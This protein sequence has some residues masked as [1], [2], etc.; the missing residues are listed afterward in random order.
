MSWLQ[1]SPATSIAHGKRADEP[2]ACASPEV[3]DAPLLGELLAEL[4]EESPI[5]VLD[6][7]PAAPANLDF[8]ARFSSGLRI[9]DLL[10]DLPQPDPEDPDD[11]P[12]VAVLARLARG[13]DPRY[14]LI[15]LWDTLDSLT[16][17]RSTVLAHHLAA[18]TTPGGRLHAMTASTAGTDSGVTAYEIVEPGRLRYRRRTA[19]GAT[20]AA[21]PPAEVERR[22]LPFRV[23]RSVL[24][25]HGIRE[26]IAVLD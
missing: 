15:L 3:H 7:G 2:T 16:A 1:R 10:R 11:A 25:R 19:G 22:L 20:Q 9:A 13:D 23:T 12:F 26:T 21:I 5:R 4:D 17:G 6:L 14:D 24:L 18:L 8:F